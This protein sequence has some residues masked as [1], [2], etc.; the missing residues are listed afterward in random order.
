MAN[1]KFN[2]IMPEG[3]TLLAEPSLEDSLAF[4]SALRKN[5]RWGKLN[6][7]Q[8]KQLPFRCWNYLT[9]KGQLALTW[10]EFSSGDTACIDIEFAEP[11]EDGEEDEL[12][13]DGL[14]KGS[15][16]AR[17]TSSS[18]SSPSTPASPTGSGGEQPGELQKS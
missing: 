4:E 13:V 10:E 11:E 6:E 14:G 17:S 2:V 1:K 8:I 3:V 16:R 9:R 7:N 15:K 12:E 18:S 5:P